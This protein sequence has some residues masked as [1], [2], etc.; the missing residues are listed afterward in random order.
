MAEV[1]WNSAKD[2]GPGSHSP[3][4]PQQAPPPAWPIWAPDAPCCWCTCHP[5]RPQPVLQQS[6]AVPWYTGSG[7]CLSY[8]LKLPHC[9]IPCVCTGVCPTL[10][11]CWC[12][13]Q[14]S[15][16]V[17]GDQSSGAR[18][19]RV[20]VSDTGRAEELVPSCQ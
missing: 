18:E 12:L 16:G 9:P 2:G 8:V 5:W 1:Q 15:A 19:G 4:H 7:P 6:L 14:C 20:A 3:T 17:G 10:R 11:V 13:P